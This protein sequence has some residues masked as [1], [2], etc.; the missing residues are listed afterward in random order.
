MKDSANR[1][2][3]F[4]AGFR[5]SDR[6]AINEF[7]DSYFSRIAKMIAANNGNEED[8]RGV[9]QSG[10]EVIYLKSKDPEFELTSS[11][12]T[13]FYS[14]CSKIWLKKL[15]DSGKMRPLPKE[16]EAGSDAGQEDD[17]ALQQARY[18]LYRQKFARLGEQCRRI[19]ELSFSKFSIKEIKEELGLSSEGYTRLR[20]HKCKEKLIRMVKEAPEYKYLKF[21]PTDF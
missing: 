14:V 6:S 7:Y 13:Y 19:I 8:A 15:R 17:A 3:Y 16:Y 20:K 4:L 18:K 1:S 10:I 5:N 21:Q 12:Y 2:S 11:I 9:F